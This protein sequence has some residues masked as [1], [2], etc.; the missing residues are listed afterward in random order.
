MIS[1]CFLLLD[2]EEKLK[3]TKTELVFFSER[4]GECQSGWI[5]QS[6]EYQEYIELDRIFKKVAAGVY[7]EEN[8]N[9]MDF[10]NE[11]HLELNKLNIKNE[12]I[13]GTIPDGPHAWIL[14]WVEPVDGS[15]IKVNA[16]YK[17]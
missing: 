5:T 13:I 11:L 8:H 14:I 1:L 7:D 3:E 6:K 9:C 4:W 10:S 17:R 12:V 2:I 15:F 16:P